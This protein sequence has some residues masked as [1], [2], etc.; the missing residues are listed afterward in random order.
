MPEEGT[1]LELD[2]LH[3]L[4]PSPT[5]PISLP[6][7]DRIAVDSTEHQTKWLACI[8]KPCCKQGMYLLFKH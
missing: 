3:H 1:L 4:L 7:L 2:T 6:V 8:Q 5:L